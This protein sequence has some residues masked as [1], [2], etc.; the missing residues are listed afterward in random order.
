MHGGKFA[1]KDG[2]Q[3]IRKSNASRSGGRDVWEKTEENDDLK[4]SF[5]ENPEADDWADLDF[6]FLENPEMPEGTAPE[7]RHREEPDR[8][9]SERNAPVQKARNRRNPAIWLIPLVVLVIAVAVLIWCMTQYTLV[10]FRI[11]PRNASMLDLREEDLTVSQY[12]KIAEKFPDCV[13]YWNVP[14]QGKTYPNSTTSLTI[15]S[16]SEQDVVTLDY[17][18]KLETVDARQCTDY[19]NLKALETRRPELTVDYDILL[20]DT[21]YSRTSR[22]ITLEAIA[23]EEISRLAFLEQLKTVTVG[24]GGSLQSFRALQSYCHDHGIDFQVELGG[25]KVGDQTKSLTVES[26]T[27]EELGLLPLLENLTSLDLVN[28]QASPETVHSLQVAYPSIKV[29]WEI[30]IGGKT[31]STEETDVDLSTVKVES[32]E[33]VEQAM[34]YLPNVK[35]LFMGEQD[36]S[37]DDMAAF[38]DRV[39]D[40]YKVVWYVRFG[41]SKPFRTDIDYFMP[42][43]DC[44]LYNVTFTD[45]TS[46]NIRYCE[47]LVAVDVGHLGVKDVSWV[48]YLTNLEYLILAHTP[49]QRIDGIENCKKLKFLELDWSGIQTLDPLKGC[50]ALEDLNIGNTFPDVSALKEM[51]WLKNIY[52]IFGSGKDAYELAQALPDTHVVASGTATVASGWRRLPNYYAMRDALHAYYMN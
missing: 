29:S 37:H 10:G 15:N 6:S 40:K 16:L 20:G 44:H 22:E 2:N 11:Y 33:Q 34:E 8:E 51:P 26:V 38:R 1:Q 14:F 31:I 24:G 13:I 47:D 49:V 39:R 25:K 35:T 23:E 48:A 17:L 42:G 9:S 5:W 50:T 3:N 46:Y 30:Q 43:R 4:Y 12:E 19:E 28:P 7:W 41:D 32:L 21:G 18:T 27:E 52:M 45:A 36:I